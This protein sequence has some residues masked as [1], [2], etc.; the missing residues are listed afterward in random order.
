MRIKP[1]DYIVFLKSVDNEYYNLSQ[2]NANSFPFI[3]NRIINGLEEKML[4]C[5]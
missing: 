2:V 5:E 1:Q 3:F 4:N